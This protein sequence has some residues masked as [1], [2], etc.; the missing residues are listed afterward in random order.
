[1]HKFLLM[2]IF[3]FCLIT[4]MNAQVGIGTASPEAGS[5][6]DISATDKGVLLNHVDLTSPTDVT[7]IENTSQDMMVF[8]TQ[9]HALDSNSEIVKD[10]VYFHNGTEWE[11]VF[12]DSRLDEDIKKLKISEFGM[13]A[14]SKV[15]FHLQ[16]NTGLAQEIPYPEASSDTYL[17]PAI[18]ERVNDTTFKVL[19]DGVYMMDSFVNMVQRSTDISWGVKMIFS[20][21]NGATWTPS[22]S[23]ANYCNHS[24]DAGVTVPSTCLL[25]E[26]FTLNANDLIKMVVFQRG[27]S[28]ISSARLDARTNPLRYSSGFKI[29][30]YPL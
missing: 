10:N 17:N 6:V 21:D 9:D 2:A 11:R 14:Y 23:K 22:P 29:I 12:T 4:L 19:L 5:A 15:H 3:T 25:Q 1:M 13:Y 24:K 30:Y 18:F 16:I 7:T 8:S 26:S 20:S 27:G 28:V